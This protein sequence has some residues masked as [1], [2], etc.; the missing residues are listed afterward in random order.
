VPQRAPERHDDVP[1]LHR[2]GRRLGQERL[3]GHVRLRVDD[4][5]L[6]PPATEL[7]L[8]PE[9]GVEADVAAAHDEDDRALADRVRHATGA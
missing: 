4:D 3:V 9:G 6:G 5:D 7:P 1:R 2:A 8:Q